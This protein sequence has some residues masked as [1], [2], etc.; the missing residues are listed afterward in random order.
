MLVMLSV[1]IVSHASCFVPEFFVHVVR[2]LCFQK[3]GIRDQNPFVHF[4]QFNL[5]F[6][7]V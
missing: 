3:K 4:L 1:H 5:M 2:K 7:P 6:V